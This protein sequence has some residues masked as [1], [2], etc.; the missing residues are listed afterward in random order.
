MREYTELEDLQSTY[1]DFYKEVYGFRPRNFTDEQWNSVEWFKG[2]IAELTIASK[3]VFA[4]EEAREQANIAK[5][6]KTVTDLCFAMGKDR[7]TVVRWMFE[8]AD[9]R[10]DWDHYCW[11]LGIPFGYFKEFANV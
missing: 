1:S 8:G 5:F 11:E 4:E 3:A 7:E 10:G 2:A 6:E 9:Y